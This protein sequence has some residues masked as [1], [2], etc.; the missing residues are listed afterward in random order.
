M[1]PLCRRVV[2]GVALDVRYVPGWSKGKD[3]APCPAAAACRGKVQ[4]EK[5]EEE[6]L[7]ADQQLPL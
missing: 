4:P 5:A 2:L 1:D 7:D 6:V 3:E